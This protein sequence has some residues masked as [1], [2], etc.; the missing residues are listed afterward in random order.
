MSSSAVVLV[1][2]WARRDDLATGSLYGAFTTAIY[3]LLVVGFGSLLWWQGAAEH[4]RAQQAI[5]DEFAPTLARV[6]SEVSPAATWATWD[7]KQAAEV[8]EE[9]PVNRAL[10]ATGRAVVIEQ[11]PAFLHPRDDW[12]EFERIQDELESLR[13]TTRIPAVGK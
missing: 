10:T 13:T 8:S 3:I 1:A 9:F 5:E 6:A 2:E 11:H 7:A 4:R 12:R